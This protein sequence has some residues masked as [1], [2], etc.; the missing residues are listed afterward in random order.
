[1]KYVLA[2]VACVLAS[3]CSST[4]YSMN[5]RAAT[6][7]ASTTV[8]S[9]AILDGVAVAKYDA[10]KAEMLLVMTDVSK[11]LDTGKIGDLPFDQA[12]AAIVK[13][14]TDKGWTQYVPAVE[15]ILDIIAAQTVPVE[16]LGADNIAII[17]MGLKS[18]STSAETSKKEWRRPDS[19]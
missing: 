9:K 1:M 17:Q 18:A 14:M 10:T 13:Y 15:G 11:F 5:M 12:K 8:A 2:L 19:R 3:G 7:Q 6:V 4:D 16:K